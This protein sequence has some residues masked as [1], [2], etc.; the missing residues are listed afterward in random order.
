MH[1][2]RACLLA[3]DTATPVTAAAIRLPDG[4]WLLEESRAPARSRELAPMLDALRR[5]AGIAW[6]DISLFAWA[7]G[8]GS[9]T[10]LRIGAAMLAGLNTGMGRPCLGLSALEIT[11]RQ[12]AADHALHVIEDARAGFAYLGR[13]DAGG[14]ALEPDACIPVAQLAARVRGAFT[15]HPPPDWPA[16]RAP[17]P[18]RLSRAEALAA[19]ADD[20]HRRADEQSLA[21]LRHPAPVY[22]QP[23]QAERL[24]HA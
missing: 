19:A 3:L 21:S 7:H 6:R 15:G 12:A 5:R 13:Y 8:P 11:A 24:A 18:P 14:R 17:L 10:G 16:D 1:P 4:E 23:S 20:A 9:F 2:P 22:L